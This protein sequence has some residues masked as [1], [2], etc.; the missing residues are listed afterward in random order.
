MDDPFTFLHKGTNADAYARRDTLYKAGWWCQVVS[1][2]GCVDEGDR[3]GLRRGVMVVV[4]V[5]GH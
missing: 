1:C 2:V 3:E 5:G 4:V